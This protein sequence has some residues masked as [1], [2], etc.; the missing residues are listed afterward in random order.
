MERLIIID[1]NA[2]LHR[3]FHA[4]PPLTTAKGELVN[5]IFGFLSMMLRIVHDLKPAFLVVTF[6]RAKPT[7]RK[8]LFK[9]YQAKRP[10]MDEG[11]SGQ[12]NR[13]HEV[14]EKM[15]VQVFEKD[16]YEADDVIGTIA[17]RATSLK[18]DKTDNATKDKISTDR[19]IEVII[20][21]GDRDILQLVT[22]RVKVY[23]PVKG[24]SE[25]KLFGEKEVEEKFGIKSSQMVDYKA[26][27]GDQSD[28]Y[29]GVGGIG[30]K[31]ASGLLSHFRT[32]E[33][34]YQN[35]DKVEN[36][37]T[38]EKLKAD[39]KEAEMS[40]KLAQI[41]TEVP[42]DFDLGKC[43]LPNFDRPDIHLLLEELQF[44]SLI[45]RL[46]NSIRYQVSGIKYKE[47][48][49]DESQQIKLF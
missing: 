10:K 35:I 2:I 38:R 34:L 43:R 16:G 46:S 36:E 5:A 20:I 39:V 12:I 45:P 26:L 32:L 11:L 6:D 25:S 44:R 29:P 15:N 14:L 37:N 3:A 42:I 7:F 13:M 17:L 28:N 22:D 23:M 48:K 31:T 49:K 8:K 19:K 21:T 24:L 30:P 47:K 1:G 27:V 33:R 40:K 4:I 18:T 9:A 41:Y